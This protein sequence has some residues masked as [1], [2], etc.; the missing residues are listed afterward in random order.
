MHSQRLVLLLAI[1]ALLPAPEA[2]AASLSY[3]VVSPNLKVRPTDKPATTPAASLKAARNEF[4]AFQIVLAS[5]GGATTGVTLKLT[6]PL[7]SAGGATIPAS[8][9]VLYRVAYYSVG[10]ASSSEGG[11]GLWPDPLVPDVDTYFGETRKAFPF[12]VPD[13]ESR[14]VWVDVLVPASAAPGSYAG[15]ISIGAGAASVGKIP[16]TLLVGS[17]SL[18]STATLAS[19][20]GMGW[21]APC[22]AHTGTD[23][24]D[25]SWNEDKACQLRALYL[26]AGVEHRFTVSDTDFQPPFGASAAPF[27]THILPL[28]AGTAGTRL[29]GA[30]LT[31]V[32]LDGG[33][34][35][36]AQ[37]VSYAKTKGF[38]DRLFYYPVDEPGSSGAAWATFVTQATALHQVD[39]A[40][41]IIITSAIQEADQAAATSN[42]DIFCP[43]INYLEDK[44]AGKY[45]GSQRAKYDAWLAAKAN[46][47]LWAYQSCM[48]HGCG[49]CGA[50]TTDSYFTGWPNRVIDSPAVQNRAFPW[51][52]FE[53]DVTGELYFETTYQLGTAWNANGQC[54]FSG[55]GDGTLFYPGK[56]TIIG[57]TKDIPVESIRMKLIREGMEDYEYL[58]QVAAKDKTKA[59]AIALALFPH[60]YDCAQPPAKLENARDQLFALLSTVVPT[61]G[62]VQPSDARP[63]DGPADGGT[64]ERRPSDSAA[65]DSSARDAGDGARRQLGGGCGCEVAIAPRPMAALAVLAV[66][67]ALAARRRRA[68]GPQPRSRPARRRATSSP[69]PSSAARYELR[70]SGPAVTRGNPMARASRASSAKV[71]GLT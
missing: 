17:F 69:A 18:P 58:V 48:S 71:S 15:E 22:Q 38:F 57:G 60:A 13:G 63:G 61:D 30:K 54:A 26:R 14:V 20:F 2:L 32:R 8:N 5:S 70:T 47:L 3:G 36:L 28:I 45:P 66:V 46:R 64:G 44:P 24:C 51:I 42:V 37:W 4:E 12:D 21:S 50:A 29:A 43:V 68:R 31:A 34:G 10:T 59:R 67:L 33:Q 39:P 6:K 19:A 49:S 1:S 9:V 16:I 25:A 65:S 40:T 52:A 7:G 41:R 11:A 55:S 23:S 27:E 62:G 35:T 53:L 56:P